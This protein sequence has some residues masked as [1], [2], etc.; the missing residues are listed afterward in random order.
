MWGSRFRYCLG[1]GARV[2]VQSSGFKP[3]PSRGCNAG[4]RFQSFRLEESFKGLG[5]GV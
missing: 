4:P 1:C 2:R 3:Q 5:F